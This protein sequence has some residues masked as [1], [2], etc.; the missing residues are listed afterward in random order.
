MN[1]RITASRDAA[2]SSFVKGTNFSE[3]KNTLPSFS[4]QKGKSSVKDGTD[5]EQREHQDRSSER[6]NKRRGKRG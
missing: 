3:K 4:A 6:I 5:T 1:V 2:L